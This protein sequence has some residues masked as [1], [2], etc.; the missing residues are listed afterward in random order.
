MASRGEV[1]RLNLIDVIA[2][3]IVIGFLSFLMAVLWYGESRAANTYHVDEIFADLMAKPYNP[4]GAGSYGTWVSEEVLFDAEN[5]AGA[6]GKLWFAEDVSPGLLAE[7]GAELTPILSGA[8]QFVGYA[9]AALMAYQGWKALGCPGATNWC[10]PA[11]GLGNQNRPMT[12]SGVPQN[13]I[14][15]PDPN[16]TLPNTGNDAFGGMSEGGDCNNTD[17]SCV[18]ANKETVDGLILHNQSFPSAYTQPCQRSITTWQSGPWGSSWGVL[19]KYSTA[20]SCAAGTLC[21]G[22]THN[23]SCVIQSGDANADSF[24]VTQASLNS[25]HQMTQQELQQAL[26]DALIAGQP[27]ANSYLQQAIN[28]LSSAYQAGALGD[29]AMQTAW[30][31]LAQGLLN[32]LSSAQKTALDSAITNAT[33]APTPQPNPNPS[34]GT[35]TLTDAS[36]TNDVKTGMEETI[37]DQAPGSIALSAGSIAAGTEPPPEVPSDKLDLSTILTTFKNGLTNL[38]IL[39]WLSSQAPVIGAGSCTVVFSLPDWIG[40]NITVSFCDYQSTVDSM[41]N[42][43]LAMVGICWTMFMLKGRGD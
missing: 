24:L 15:W 18:L 19:C 11:Q 25:S 16:Q 40:G 3:V 23:Q 33:P 1:E 41:G 13:G 20:S 30:G 10:D 35:G 8:G 27:N 42:A 12:L 36:V 4:T 14:M 2:W 31:Q 29:A 5:T 26:Q 37:A 6:M 38:P 9:G 21:A 39:S 17:S 43:L 34:P 28:A 7:I 32:M 22:T